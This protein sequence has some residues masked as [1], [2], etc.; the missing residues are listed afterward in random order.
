MILLKDSARK[1]LAKEKVQGPYYC[2]IYIHD[3]L[4]KFIY[5]KHQYVS[6]SKVSCY[7]DS[8]CIRYTKLSRASRK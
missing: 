8:L 7:A 2:L 1:S 5:H 4:K 3:Y 6:I